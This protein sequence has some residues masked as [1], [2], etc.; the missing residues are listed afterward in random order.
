MLELIFQ[1]FI[2]W[3]YSL[4]LE[5]WEYFS[6]SLLDIMSL[7]LAYIKSHVPVIDDI[8]SVLLAVGWALL[9]GN[10]V[11]QA[12]KSMASGLGFEAEDPKILFGRTF[13]FAFLLVGSPQICEIGL[14]LTANV[15]ALLKLPDA[16]DVHLVDAGIFGNLLAAWLIV[17]IF[18]IIIMFKVLKLLLKIAEQ[19]VVLSTLT[20]TAPLAFAMGGSRGT[21]AIFTG[22]CRM[23][24][25]MCLL[26]VTNVMFFKLLLSAMTAIPSGLDVI[27]WMVL[28]SAIAKVARKADDIITRIGLN[29]AM[30]GSD[31][32]RSFPGMLAATVVRGAVSQVMKTV[33][34]A[35]GGA[36]RAAAA[37]GGAAL[38]AGGFAAGFGRGGGA[39]RGK[40]GSSGT[41]RG[42]AGTSGAA[43]AAGAAGIGAAGAA[44]TAGAAAGASHL[45]GQNA[46]SLTSAPQEP[47][48]PGVNRQ[49]TAQQS[50]AVQNGGSS[51][52]VSPQFSQQNNETGHSRKSS[53][54]AGMR[55]A[56]GCVPTP[57]GS[58]GS[59]HT[60]QG[61]GAA[62]SDTTQHASPSSVPRGDFPRSGGFGGGRCGTFGD[63][64]SGGFGAGRGGSFG[65]GT[66]G[67]DGSAGSDG[68]SA[69]S[70]GRGQSGAA[71]TA[72]PS[73]A[74]NGAIRRGTFT[75]RQV[76]PGTG[77][78]QEAAHPG[79]AGTPRTS[80]PQSTP[81]QAGG[82]RPSGVERGQTAKIGRASGSPQPGTAGTGHAAALESSSVKKGAAPGS[83]AGVSPGAAGTTFSA[84]RSTRY[85]A[86]E[87]AVRQRSAAPGTSGT[88]A[89]APG[90]GAPSTRAGSGQSSRTPEAE[91][92]STRREKVH[93]ERTEHTVKHTSGQSGAA[94]TAP[95]GPVQQPSQ[96]AQSG[97][98]VPPVTG[99]SPPKRQGA[100]PARQESRQ[101]SVPGKPPAHDTSRP[102][103]N[104]P[105]ASASRPE[106]QRSSPVQQ[107]RG[108]AAAPASGGAPLDRPGTAG[109]GAD[110]SHTPEERQTA[111]KGPE[112]TQAKP[113]QDGLP[114]GR[115]TAPGLT[116]PAKK[117][118]AD[119]K[120]P[121]R[122]GHGGGAGHGG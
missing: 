78:S 42:A 13:V 98:L 72:A 23:F 76:K 2:E 44:G 18:D 93:S 52:A 74:G 71:G 38:G 49:G 24:G 109:T 99:V 86:E 35:A 22:W 82:S 96:A 48:R 57:A 55:R 103:R 3:M 10:L 116:P 6:A 63:S 45:G 4:V 37:A 79:A 85:K 39:R 114:P 17:I 83:P 101:T 70:T 75:G 77:G 118:A 54:P 53:V 30:T 112:R 105:P 69:G 62:A 28:I 27:P 12:M 61:T 122:S 115:R 60:G 68:T 80:A 117:T 108:R 1:G 9:L 50:A 7:D 100:G 92:R 47:G 97:R 110:R 84:A 34:A 65:G 102:V 87:K 88:T 81:S 107:E 59:S 25:S 89:A 46:A 113:A 20:I 73:A 32:G 119:P 51:T 5:C 36:G 58:A 90:K 16:I 120:R 43:G 33:G 29:P 104:G 19:Y 67:R 106:R 111:R 41:G 8:L 40:P 15:M 26:M 121:D 21:A 14:N 64:R 95:T 94:G 11:F 91:A 56:P 31:R 66:R